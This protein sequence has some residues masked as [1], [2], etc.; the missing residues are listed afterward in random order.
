MSKHLNL[1]EVI[2]HCRTERDSAIRWQ[3]QHRQEGAL[4]VCTRPWP[5][6]A[7]TRI[8]LFV[9]YWADKLAHHEETRAAMTAPTRALAQLPARRPLTA[10]AIRRRARA[11]WTYWLWGGPVNMLRRLGRALN[12]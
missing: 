2:K 4:C 1:D 12:F 6:E 7:N 11:D 3:G 9:N 8:G 10:Q 5:C